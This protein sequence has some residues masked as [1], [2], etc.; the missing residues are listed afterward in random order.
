MILPISA[1][2]FG[3]YAWPRLFTNIEYLLT[4][5]PVSA[6]GKRKETEMDPAVDSYCVVKVM[7]SASCGTFFG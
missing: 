7:H 4:F 6:T 2:L 3:T 1:L 5:L